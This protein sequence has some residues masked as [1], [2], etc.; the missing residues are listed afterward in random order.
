MPDRSLPFRQRERLT[1][2]TSL[3]RIA[4]P[5]STFPGVPR[6]SASAITAGESSIPTL[7]DRELLLV[8]L[9]IETLA[10]RIFLRAPELRQVDADIQA[11]W[12][13]PGPPGRVERLERYARELKEAH[14]L[15]VGLQARL[16]SPSSLAEE[17]AKVR[18]RLLNAAN[19]L[20]I[21]LVVR[22]SAFEPYRQVRSHRSLARSVCGIVSVYLAHWELIRERTPVPM[23]E[24]ERALQLAKE[25]SGVIQGKHRGC[26]ALGPALRQRQQLF[27]LLLREYA[28]LRRA[29]RFLY[30]KKEADRLVPSL[31]ARKRGRVERTATHR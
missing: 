24:L 17:L 18:Q 9:D 8:N 4:A 5:A 16:P 12:Q 27:T 13:D 15:C 31:Y 26:D 2:M 1:F 11:R 7:A 3:L 30:E 23:A 28:A 6:P 19:A 14:Y 20:A 22:A 21:A 10:A 29:A 25:F